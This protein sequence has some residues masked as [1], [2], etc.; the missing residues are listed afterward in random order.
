MQ[1]QGGK[2]N[3]KKRAEI[4]AFYELYKKEKGEKMFYNFKCESCGKAQEVEIAIKDYD[5]EKD[6]QKCSCGGK[7]KR[8]IERSGI[9][10]AEGQGWCGSS[11]GNVI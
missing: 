3:K 9:A 2:M 6:K 4:S 10:T 7:L 1:A 8:V 5:K 11:K